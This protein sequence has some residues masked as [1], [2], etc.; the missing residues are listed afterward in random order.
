VVQR[1]GGEIEVQSEPGKGSS[2]RLLLPAARVRHILPSA[3]P[4]TG[5]EATH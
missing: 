3:A 5:I 4:A 2:F 1:H